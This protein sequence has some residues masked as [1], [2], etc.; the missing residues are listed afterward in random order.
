MKTV[1]QLQ[2]GTNLIQKGDTIIEGNVGADSSVEITDGALTINGNIENGARINIKTSEE[3]RKKKTFSSFDDSMGDVSFLGVKSYSNASFISSMMSIN[4]GGRDHLFGGVNINNRILTNDHVEVCGGGVYKIT[5][6][7]GTNFRS[8]M[9]TINN[10]S[11]TG[12][13]TA[14]IDGVSYSGNEI[15]VSGTNTL[16]VLVDGQAPGAQTAA[17]SSASSSANENTSMPLKLIINGNI[18]DNVTISSDIKIEAQ[19]IG[20]NFKLNSNHEGITA[21]NVGKNAAIV[22]HGA[23]KL[24][25][26]GSKGRFTS[27]Q[28]GFEAGELGNQNIIET[29]DKITIGNT[30]NHCSF[31][32]RQYGIQA[33]NIGRGTTILVRDEINVGNIG[34]DSKIESSNYG[35]TARNIGDNVTVT[36]RDGVTARK[37]GNQSNITSRNYGIDIRYDVKNHCQLT[38]RN[39]ISIRNVGNSTRLESKVGGVKIANHTG[40]HVKILARDTVDLLNIGHNAE[41][42]STQDRVLIRNIG[43]DSVV[44]ARNDIRIDGRCPEPSSLILS[45]GHGKI[46]RP[47]KTKTGTNHPTS[48]AQQNEDPTTPSPHA[49]E[50]N[51]AT[52][53]EAGLFSIKNKP[54]PKQNPLHGLQ[55]PISLELM[56]DPVLLIL[57]GY[58]YE[59]SAIIKWLS[60]HRA[61]PITRTKMKANQAVDQVLVSNRIISDVTQ[62]IREPGASSSDQVDA[63][64]TLKHQLQS[65]EITELL[66]SPIGLELPEDPVLLTIDG[67]TYERKEIEDWLKKHSTS[68][69]TRVALTEIQSIEAVLIS[70]RAVKEIIEVINEMQKTANALT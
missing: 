39:G 21:K 66:S 36:V 49:V 46:R 59:R 51:P 52:S 25:Q 30:G 26:V 57:D 60:E 1:S 65:E 44:V 7:G 29:R 41:I 19:N 50:Y 69:M 15:I 16:H 40:N 8:I 37:V 28:Y 56:A 4:V 24:A 5:G 43:I 31:T 67:Y 68:P 63:S 23:I 64:S 6:G 62:K 47:K 34:N 45:S 70:N 32:S 35:L 17:S 22:T 10:K 58:T 20:R 48:H 61:S 54:T 53:S 42:T 11:S 18:G 13:A 33:G 3:Y 12:T 27:L 38:A 55:C 14:T 2:S 9:S